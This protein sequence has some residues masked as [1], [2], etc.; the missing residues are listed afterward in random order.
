MNGKD[1]CDLRPDS[2][3][4]L[5]SQP[6]GSGLDSIFLIRASS[7]SFRFSSAAAEILRKL[8]SFS[9]HPSMDSNAVMFSSLIRSCFKSLRKVIATSCPLRYSRVVVEDRMAMVVERARESKKN[10]AIEGD[11]ANTTKDNL[12]RTKSSPSQI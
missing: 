5:I 2:F 8:R 7:S 10:S 6:S 9:C 3:S 4:Y 11:T 1:G 12:R